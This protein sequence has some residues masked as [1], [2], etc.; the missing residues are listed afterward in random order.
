[1]IFIRKLQKHTFIIETDYYVM[2]IYP[3]VMK[4][5]DSVL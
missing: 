4:I 2:E 3:F 5:Y 1:M